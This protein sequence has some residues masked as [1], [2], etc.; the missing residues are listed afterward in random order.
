MHSTAVA[1]SP[2]PPGWVSVVFFFPQRVCSDSGASCLSSGRPHGSARGRA[3]PKQGVSR[4]R[5]ASDDPRAFSSP[6]VQQARRL[7][8]RAPGEET[9]VLCHPQFVVWQ[10]H[11]SARVFYCHVWSESTCY[12]R[13]FALAVVVWEPLFTLY[14]RRRYVLFWCDVLVSLKVYIPQRHGA[15]P[16]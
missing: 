16:L 7:E 3:M 14:L 5:C 4:V 15:L 9:V 1:L 2:P 6:A 12:V 11:V 13:G 10:Q 8:L